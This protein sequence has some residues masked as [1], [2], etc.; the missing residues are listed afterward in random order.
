MYAMALQ[1]PTNLDLLLEIRDV[2]NIALETRKQAKRTNGRVNVIEE[3]L[4]EVD[5]WKSNL[6]AVE[7]YKSTRKKSP[8]DYLKQALAILA[9]MAAII[10][11][12]VNYVV[13]N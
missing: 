3:K 11:A 4:E 6:Q 7:A 13:E 10:L 12:L 9:T 1:N 2:K 5:V 8:Q